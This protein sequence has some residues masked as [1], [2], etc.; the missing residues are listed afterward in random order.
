MTS[1]SVQRP[2]I[3]IGAGGHACSLLEALLDQQDQRAVRGLL[4]QDETQ[5]G[6]KVLG[7]DV[8]GGD[9]V[10][11]GLKPSETELVNAVGGVGTT[12]RRDVFERYE[13]LSFSFASVFHSSAIHSRY[14]RLGAGVQLLA[15]SYVGPETVLAENVLVNTGALVEHNCQLAAHVHIAPNATLLGD[16]QVGAN[17]HVGAGATVLQGVSIG[18]HCVVGA[19]A[20]VLNS[21]KAGQTVV[22]VPATPKHH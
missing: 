14:A 13:A 22:G 10:L 15:N 5:W 11:D 9:D 7:V 8:L 19:G 17:T 20:V 1:P 12:L 21:V 16:V 18:E 2:L 6:S 3:L 4:S